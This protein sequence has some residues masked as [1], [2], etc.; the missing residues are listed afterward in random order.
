[1]RFGIRTTLLLIRVVPAGEPLVHLV[2]FEEGSGLLMVKLVLLVHMNR[3]IEDPHSNRP[4]LFREKIIAFSE[5]VTLVDIWGF[6][7]YLAVVA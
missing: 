5:I 2:G 4:S 1:M 6:V 3:N 7:D